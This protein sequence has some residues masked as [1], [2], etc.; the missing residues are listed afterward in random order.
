MTVEV[1]KLKNICHYWLCSGVCFKN[2]IVGVLSREQTK[3]ISWL[4]ARR[5]STA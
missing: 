3:M 1:I 2:Y 4:A 5:T